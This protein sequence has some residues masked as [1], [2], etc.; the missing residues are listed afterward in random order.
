MIDRTRIGQLFSGPG[1]YQ[2]GAALVGDWGDLHLKLAV[3]NGADG[4]SDGWGIVA[5]GE[6]KIG[7]GAKQRE[8]ALGNEGFNATFG[9]GYFKD[10]S[11]IAGSDFGSALALDAYVTVD[12][13]SF[14]AEILDADEEFASRALGNVTDDATPYSATAGILLG[15]S[16]WEALVR[17]Q[18]LDNEVGATILTA[19]LNYYV[20]GH[21]TKWQVNVSNYDDDN[22]DGTIFQAGLSIGLGDPN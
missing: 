13:L 6:W 11:D 19:G 7:T 1:A 8:G 15:D 22:I 5:R 17:Y 4:I 14:H 16:R 2:P 9:L 12:Q 18:D 3:Q 21:Q 10:D 20:S